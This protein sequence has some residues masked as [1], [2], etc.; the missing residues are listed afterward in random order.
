[1]NKQ[2]LIDGLI[3]LQHRTCLYGIGQQDKSKPTGRC[4]CKYGSSGRGEQSGC[5]E[6][7]TVIGI[8]QQM[9]EAEYAYVLG[10]DEIAPELF[11]DK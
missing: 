3:S 10:R 1:M 7:R 11:L 4:D 5:P 8:I 9:S 6:L 2:Q